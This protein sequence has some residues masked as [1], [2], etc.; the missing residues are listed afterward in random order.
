MIP[1]HMHYHAQLNVQQ[2][3]V[4]A[5]DHLLKERPELF[6]K[7]DTVYVCGA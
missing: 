7:G 4:W 5:R 1:T 2:V 3:V 6:A